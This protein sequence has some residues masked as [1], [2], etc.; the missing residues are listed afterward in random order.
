MNTLQ[1][2]HTHTTFCDGKDTVEE[3][4]NA[5][6]EKGFGKDFLRHSSFR[7]ELPCAPIFNNELK[8]GYL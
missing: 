8:E 4:I 3:M 5:A 1:N 7:V 6:L 2:L